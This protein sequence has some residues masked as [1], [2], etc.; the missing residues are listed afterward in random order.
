MHTSDFDFDH[1]DFGTETSKDGRM[2]TWMVLLYD[3]C[4]EHKPV[5]ARLSELDWDFAGRYHDSDPGVK[6]H[7][8][9]VILFKDGR[10]LA[11]VACDLNLDSR[12]LRAWDSKK[13][14]LR[15]LCHR[16]HPDKFQYPT[17]GIFGTVADKAIAQCSKS[18]EMSETQSVLEVLALLD[19]FDDIVQYND[20]FKLVCERGCF[21]AF[22]RMGSLGIRLIEEHNANVYRR[23]QV[24]RNREYYDDLVHRFDELPFSEKVDFLAKIDN[25][26]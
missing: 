8:H 9:I 24:V 26:G 10:K 7:C 20:F 13:R 1:D 6:P 22:R 21:S 11:D 17:D 25:R 14:A 16:D 4:E 19:S 2:R 23:K 12:W 5:K 18:N 3:D 15:Y